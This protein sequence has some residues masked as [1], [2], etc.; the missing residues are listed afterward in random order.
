MKI[1]SSLFAFFR[2]LSIVMCT[3]AILSVVFTGGGATGSGFLI[4]VLSGGLATLLTLT[5]V[6]LDPNPAL[7]WKWSV[8]TISLILWIWLTSSQATYLHEAILWASVWTVVLGMGFSLHYLARGKTSHYFMGVFGICVLLHL[9]IGLAEQQNWSFPLKNLVLINPSN[10]LITGPYYNPSHFSGFLILGN[11]VLLGTIFLYRFSLLTLVCVIAAVLLNWL[12]L[13]TDASS[14]PMVMGM[15]PLMMLLWIIQKNWKVGTVLSLISMGALLWGSTWF[16]SPTGQNWFK[17][18]QARIGLNNN[19]P[20]FVEGRKDVWDYGKRMW[21]DAPLMGQGIGQFAVL[22]PYY[23]RDSRVTDSS[24]DRQFVNYT[25][26]DALQIG[27]ELGWIGL[28]LFAA[29]LFYVMFSGIKNR[30]AS[31]LIATGATIGYLLSGIFDAH[32]T[33]IPAT[34]MVFYALAGFSVSKPFTKPLPEPS[35]RQ[36]LDGGLGNHLTQSQSD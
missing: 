28:F 6:T 36:Q 26:N 10:P 16:V 27:S 32:I 18:N 7:S 31:G 5:T 1:R 33:A 13:K 12:N 24:V 20:A 29:L 11:A 17:D 19:W 35:S 22:S 34:M 23:R 15:V 3:I 30:T 25:H 9:G 14:I 8:L 21:D 4:L 2:L